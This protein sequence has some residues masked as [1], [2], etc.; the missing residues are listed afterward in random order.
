LVTRQLDIPISL[1]AAGDARRLITDALRDVAT[2]AELDNAVLLTS[3]LVTNAIR[4]ALMSEDDML[5]VAVDVSPGRARIT[6][7]D[8]GPGF[9][10]NDVGAGA[11]EPGTDWGLQ[12]VEALS[13]AWGVRE[14]PDGFSVWAELGFNG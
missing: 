4:H 5:T 8:H 9:S 14:E 7:R 13:D 3:E 2:Q 1:G 11:S 12:L 6:V 10:K